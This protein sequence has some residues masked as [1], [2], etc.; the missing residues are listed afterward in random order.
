MLDYN[1]QQF[2]TLE[3]VANRHP[4]NVKLRMALADRYRYLGM[5]GP[6]RDEYRAIL[7]LAPNNKRAREG[8]TALER[9]PPKT[10]TA[11][12]HIPTLPSASPR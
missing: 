6:A 4:E 7:S 8:L 2:N 3:A 11:S 10:E 1:V 5:Q 12:A 9:Q